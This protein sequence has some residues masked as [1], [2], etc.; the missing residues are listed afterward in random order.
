MAVSKA[1]EAGSKAVICASTGTPRRPPPP[2]RAVG[3][4]CVSLYPKARSR[5][6]NYRSGHARRAVLSVDGNFDAALKLVVE[7][8]E[9]YPLTLVTRLNPFRI[10]GRRAA[11]SRSV[12]CLSKPRLPVHA[13]WQRR[14]YHG[15]LERLCGISRAFPTKYA[16]PE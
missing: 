5:S 1:V 15:L 16:L 7:L 6:E 14:Q 11:R 9:K 3:L 4:K 10:E 12:T 8:S 2:T 13:S